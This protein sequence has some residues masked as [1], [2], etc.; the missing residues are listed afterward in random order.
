MNRILHPNV[1][2]IRV[3]GKDKEA[4][5]FAMEI[6]HDLGWFYQQDSPGLA[7]DRVQR[8]YEKYPELF[9]KGC[10]HG[11]SALH[12]ILGREVLES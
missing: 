10:A 8:L 12:R 6:L 11:V 3:D 2:V 7:I 4:L 1:D 5:E 9:I